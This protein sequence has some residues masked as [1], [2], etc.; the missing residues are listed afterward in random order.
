MGEET[1]L[2][3][4][5]KT[6]STVGFVFILFLFF[7]TSDSFMKIL[8]LISIL[9]ICMAI[10]VQYLFFVFKAKYILLTSDY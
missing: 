4:A 7:L 10:I 5:K 8:D 3:N 2:L 1:P 6:T 9:C